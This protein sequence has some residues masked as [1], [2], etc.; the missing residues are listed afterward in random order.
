VCT[1]VQHVYWINPISDARMTS[2]GLIG[3][4]R[5]GSSLALALARA[6]HPISLVYSPNHERAEEL[7]ARLGTSLAIA[8]GQ[9]L[10]LRSELVFLTVPDGAVRAVA[11][12][13]PWRAGQSVVHCS[14][15]L[16]LSAL[17]AVQRAGGLRGCLHPLQTFPSRFVDAAAFHAIACG[18]EAD[19]A[20]TGELEGFVR[21]LGAQVVRLEGVD[22]VRYH[23]AA[24]FASNYVL[25]LHVAAQRCFTLAGLSEPLARTA[26]GPLTL[27]AARRLAQLP[28]EQALTG[29]LARGDTETIARQLE[30]LSVEPELRAL[31]AG[32]G[33]LL[34]Q[35]PLALEPA[36]RAELLTL[37][38]LQ[39]GEP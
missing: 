36:Q 29:P 19:G 22:R 24:V 6:G 13:L 31:Y 4:G 10:A 16:G 30:S 37:L 28:L 25:A 18:V 1:I 15:A 14:G 27:G 21:Q 39:A 9:E 2:I 5:L 38:D 33:A 26:L 3:A 20:L 35:L 17:D 32:L 23:A 34:L 11:D 7:A 12:A 8:S